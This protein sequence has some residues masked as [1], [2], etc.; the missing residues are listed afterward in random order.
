MRCAPWS[1]IRPPFSFTETMCWVA[2]Q[3]NSRLSLHNVLP[4]IAATV[5]VFPRISKKGPSSSAIVFTATFAAKPGLP[6][7][8]ITRSVH[9]IVMY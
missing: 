4:K 8:S 6:F 2:E 5:A 9:D 3:V 7:Y 1:V